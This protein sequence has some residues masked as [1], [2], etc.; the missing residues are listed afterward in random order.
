MFGAEI[1]HQTASLKTLC[2]ILPK[3]KLKMINRNQIIELG[4][5]LKSKSLKKSE[6]FK[7][8]DFEKR[9]YLINLNNG[10]I[11]IINDIKLKDREISFDNI[12]DFINWH[13][14]FEK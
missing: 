3:Q 1:P 11:Q 7:H 12:D 2:A 5:I 8:I 14:K 6:D 13:N 10:I 4:Y 9:P